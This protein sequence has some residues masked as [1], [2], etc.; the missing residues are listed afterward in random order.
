MV[1]TFPVE[2]VDDDQM[3]RIRSIYMDHNQFNGELPEDLFDIASGRLMQLLLSDNRFTG[4]FPGDYKLTTFMQ[5]LELQNNKF[6]KIDK[7]I[8]DLNVFE[9]G[10]LVNFRADCDVC[11]C[12]FFC[13]NGLCYK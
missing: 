2:W 3:T 7:D 4:D 5:Q 1:G 8:C 13:D 6:D 9:E 11:E 10:E 12:D